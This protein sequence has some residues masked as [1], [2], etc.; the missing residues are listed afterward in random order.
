MTTMLERLR[1]LDTETLSP[2]EMIELRLYARQIEGEYRTQGYEVPEWLKERAQLLDRDIAAKR[3]DALMKRLRELE[4]QEQT[5]KTAA[6]KRQDLQAE[7]E[8]INAALGKAPVQ[9]G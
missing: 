9:V 2:D 8:R 4:A 1:G 3:T 7:R 6:E 5:L